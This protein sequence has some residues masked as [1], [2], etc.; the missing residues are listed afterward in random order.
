[1]AINLTGPFDYP[2]RSFLFIITALV[3]DKLLYLS[4][5]I[6]SSCNTIYIF[7]FVPQSYFAGTFRTITMSIKCIY[8]PYAAFKAESLIR[9][10]AHRAHINHIAGEII[11]N[12]LLYICADLRN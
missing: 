4:P 9:Q 11:I 8:K 12:S 10:C 2:V 1:M 7:A 6:L 3:T 5:F